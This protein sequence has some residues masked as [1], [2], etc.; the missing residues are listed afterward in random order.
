MTLL[1]IEINSDLITTEDIALEVGTILSDD[2]DQ[3]ELADFDTTNL[4]GE[5]EIQ[6]DGVLL[7]NPNDQFEYLSEG[8][9]AFDTFSF[10][11][12]DGSAGS[13]TTIID[14]E[15]NGVNDAPVG[16]DDSGF[17]ATSG[18]TRL[19]SSDDLLAND[20][21]AENDI[22]S[23][24]EVTGA[25]GGTAEIDASGNVLFHI[26]PNFTG[27]A[28][29][30]YLV[31]DGTTTA[32]ETTTVEIEV[33]NP[34][35]DWPSPPPAWDWFFDL[36]FPTDDGASDRDNGFMFG[37]WT[38][39]LLSGGPGIENLFG[40]FGDDALSG[41]G[42]DDRLF[43]GPGNDRLNGG[44]GN[45]I[46]F[47]GIGNDVFV[48]DED[49]GWDVIRVFE[50]SSDTSWIDIIFNQSSQDSIEIQKTGYDSFDD[51]QIVQQGHHSVVQ[52]LDGS[53]ITILNTSVSSLTE[54]H[55][56]F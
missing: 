31:S 3:I 5:L 18:S 21:D 17:F 50:T 7:Y 35:A 10:E 37:I 32:A 53:S 28:S 34:I 1:D 19:L 22:L 26:D 13:T 51:L 43:G 16:N 39:D 11:T 20:T 14:I 45:D 36:F 15:I 41:N 6:P 48:F 24:S 4:F 40:G 30:D 56:T 42:G 55:F 9:T 38:D 27:T 33:G 46:L 12:D 47:G 29:F 2:A 52:F 49:S 44:Q 25:V 54:D 23:I 8:E